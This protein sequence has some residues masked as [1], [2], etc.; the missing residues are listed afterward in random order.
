MQDGHGEGFAICKKPPTDDEESYSDYP[1][2]IDEEIYISSSVDT[3]I[4]TMRSYF[5]WAIS[6]P[7]LL[8]STRALSLRGF[9]KHKLKRVQDGT[10]FV[11]AIQQAMN[12]CC[13]CLLF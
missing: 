3:F 6:L 4:L 9:K 13:M 5:L 12:Q 11:L 7:T 1:S 8:L 2:D 10:Q